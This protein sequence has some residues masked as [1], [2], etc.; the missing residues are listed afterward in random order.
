MYIHSEIDHVEVNEL[1]WWEGLTSHR[2]TVARLATIK[3]VP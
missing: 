1:L 3:L 2:L